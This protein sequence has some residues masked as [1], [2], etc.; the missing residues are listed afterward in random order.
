M[1]LLYQLSPHANNISPLFV[2]TPHQSITFPECKEMFLE[3]CLAWINHE[4]IEVLNITDY[5]QVIHA[6][7]SL[8]DSGYN[9]AVIIT[10]LT[11]S[12]VL[13]KNND[14]QVTYPYI[15]NEVHADTIDPSTGQAS[16]GVWPDAA[17]LEGPCGR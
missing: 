8:S 7:R 2:I 5:D 9:K 3:D 11:A 4:M 13:G 17:S 14:G 6:K 16:A 15:W 10:D 1:V 12:Y